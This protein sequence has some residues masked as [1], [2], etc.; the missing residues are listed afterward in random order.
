MKFRVK[1]ELFTVD[2]EHL[3]RAVKKRCAETG[4]SVRG[5]SMALGYAP[6]YVQNVISR[7]GG[8]FPVKLYAEI[9]QELGLGP[10]HGWR[11]RG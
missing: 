6:S 7:D 11:K 1:G 8:T 2:A 10:E 4:R 5:L 3:R 9:E